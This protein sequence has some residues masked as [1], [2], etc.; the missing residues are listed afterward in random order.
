MS[1]ESAAAVEPLA[2]LAGLAPDEL[3]AL[4]LSCGGRPTH[5]RALLR[6]LHREGLPDPA[7]VRPFL[8]RRLVDALQAQA[9]VLRPVVLEAA[10]STDGPV[11]Y[12]L[13]L[14]DGA[15]IEAVDIP[16]AGRTTLC[17]STQ[18]G[19]AQGCS[20]CRTATM[21]LQRNLS[22]GEITG[23]AA[24]L[25]KLIEAEGRELTNVVLMGMGEP[26][27]NYAAVRRAVA[28][29]THDSGGGVPPRRVTVS[30]AGLPAGIRRLAADFGGKVA[31][32]VSLTGT[33]DEQRDRLMPVNR[34]HPLA[35]LLAACRDYPLPG[36]RSITIE[37]VLLGGETDRDEDADRLVA[38]LQD[39]PVKVNLIPFNPFPG[40]RHEAPTAGA[41][42][43]FFRRMNAAGV[44][45]IVRQPRGREVAAACGMLV[46]R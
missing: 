4:V 42:D 39:I 27:A 29:L 21:G 7:E 35:E 33:T 14:P 10:R 37:V 44:R 25:R 45:T 17:V 12:A 43:R 8:G 34:R 15:R 1:H 38:L 20:F 2:D 28:V 18:V 19:C 36:G 40:C 16:E 13:G 26:L 41:V 30:T 9:E 23:Q 11:R 22:A 6:A 3:E 32:A 31:L 5:A 46:A 24:V